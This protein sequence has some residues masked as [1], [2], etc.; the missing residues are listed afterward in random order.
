VTTQQRWG[1]EGIQAALD[2]VCQPAASPVI[3]GRKETEENEK[4]KHATWGIN[5]AMANRSDAGAAE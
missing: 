1:A 5:T 3:E 2:V 4:E